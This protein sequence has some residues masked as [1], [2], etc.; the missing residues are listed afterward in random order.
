MVRV[1]RFSLHPPFALRPPFSELFWASCPGAS[2]L[3]TAVVSNPSSAAPS[4]G[5]EKSHPDKKFI[6]IFTNFKSF[7]AYPNVYVNRREKIR[8]NPSTSFIFRNS[9]SSLPPLRK[10]CI[11]LIFWPNTLKKFSRYV[12]M[13]VLCENYVLPYFVLFNILLLLLYV[14]V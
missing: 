3:S 9:T 6:L 2:F 4:S 14:I 11:F 1:E 13:A 8:V 12:T 5:T 7:A 10:S